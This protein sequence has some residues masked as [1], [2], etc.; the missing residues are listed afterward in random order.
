MKQPAIHWIIIPLFSSLTVSLS[1]AG[2]L[3]LYPHPPNPV[4]QAGDR[5][6]TCA[7]LETE[8]SALE[9]LTYSYKPG[10]YNDPAH[11]AAIW[12]GVLAPPAWGYFAYS[13]AAEYYDEKRINDARQRIEVLRRLKA[14]RR[15]YE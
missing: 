11:G 5:E 12:G 9:P 4:Y 3:A 7:Q 10:F 8:L 15:C 6:L 14:Y 2:E 13:G 1:H